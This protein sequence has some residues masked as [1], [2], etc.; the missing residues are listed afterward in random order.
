[1][2]TYFHCLLQNEEGDKAYNLALQLPDNYVLKPQREGGGNNVYGEDIPPF[3]KSL[4]KERQAYILMGLISPRPTQNYL[5]SKAA[6]NLPVL[7]SIVS[8]FGVYG[9]IL[10][11]V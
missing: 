7:S 11:W 1:M 4:G 10:G 6:G 2:L 3:I 8:E 9:V 5:I